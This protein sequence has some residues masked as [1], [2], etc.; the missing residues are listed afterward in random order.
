AGLML[1]PV[2]LG[3]SA[4]EATGSGA[5]SFHQAS[6]ADASWLTDV[7]AVMLHSAAMLA[8]MAAV[9][10]LVYDK[11]GVRILRTAWVNLDVVWAGSLVLAGA[12]TLFS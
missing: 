12:F 6:V 3:L 11:L 1:V 7:A 4:A 9:A 2:L 8:V 5:A 10:L